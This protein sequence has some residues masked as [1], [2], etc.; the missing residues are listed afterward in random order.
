MDR[1]IAPNTVVAGQ[2]DTA[3]A[4]G[5]PG[6]ATDGNPASNIPATQWPAYQYNAIQE[7]LMA[8]IVGAGITADRTNNA[9]LLAAI[10]ALR[11]SSSILTDTGIANAYT[12]VNAT[13]L[14]AGTWIDG[15]VQQV[16]I[17]HANTGASTYAPDGLPAI[18]IYGLGLQPLQGGELALN[19]TA[20]LMR[21][22]IAGVNSGN[23][24]AVLMECAGGAQQIAPATQSQHAV[25]LG[26]VRLRLTSNLTLYVSTSGSDSNNGLTSGTAFATI[27]KAYSVLGQNYDLAGQYTATISVGA[28]TFPALNAYFP[29]VGLN[30]AGSVVINGAGSA[31]IISTST[32]GSN[33]VSATGGAQFTLSNLAV[34]TSGSASNG[35][36]SANG[37]SIAIGAGVTFNGCVNAHMYAVSAG[38]IGVNANYAIAGSAN[39]HITSASGQISITAGITVTITGSPTFSGGFATSNYAGFI[40]A[41]SITFS[42]SASGPRYSVGANG[43]INT[44]GGGASYFPGSISGTAATGGQYV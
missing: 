14:V 25:Q 30:G 29:I 27:Q 41:I 26:Q 20:V 34:S 33:A 39:T 15:V 37:G 17:A 8:V 11:K 13:P 24:I 12:A 22:T 1:L 4:T 28:G 10:K 19:G 32:S 18:P 3:P 42:G 31:T 21:L 23:P 44:N 40:S 9:Q 16:K 38:Y 36:Y 5:T 7:E 6:Y 2:A 43:V 35:V